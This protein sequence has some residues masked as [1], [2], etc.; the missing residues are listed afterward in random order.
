MGLL[1]TLLAIAVL[2]SHSGQLIPGME[3]VQGNAAVECFFIISGFYMAMIL[4]ETYSGQ[5][6]NF[7]KARIL[8]IFPM[9]WMVLATAVIG[10]WMR[11]YQP[12]VS[13][14]SAGTWLAVVASN[15]L[16]FTQD[17]FQFLQVGQDGSLLLDLSR[18]QSGKTTGLFPVPQAWT[19]ALEVTFYLVAPLLVKVRTRWLILIMLASFGLREAHLYLMIF[20]AWTYYF[21]PFQVGFFVAG[22]VSYRLRGF[23]AIGHRPA[24]G[25]AAIVVTSVMIFLGDAPRINSLLYLTVAVSLPAIFSASRGWN[26]DNAVGQLSYPIY[27]CH[28]EVITFWAGANPRA[29]LIASVAVSICLIVLAMPIEHIRH[30]FRMRPH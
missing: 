26:W 27:L 24:I 11:G 15:V 16:L 12:D 6:G 20:D 25:I 7:F 5:P 28:I 4:T 19:L 30:R 17:V 10:L 3:M 9:Y 22:M 29:A 8:R 1:R 23:L 2:A 13:P 18:S 14:M 21:F